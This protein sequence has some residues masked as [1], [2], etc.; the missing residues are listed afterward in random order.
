MGAPD[1]TTPAHH[2]DDGDVSLLDWLRVVADRHVPDTLPA[3]TVPVA[4]LG[5]TSTDD[6]QDPTLS[7]PRQLEA[8]RRALPE[9]FV[10]VAKFYDVESGRTPLDQ[11]GTGTAHERFN[12]PIPRDGGINDLLTEATRP[13][14]RFVAVVSESIERIARTTYL[15]TKIEHDLEQAGVVLLAA[16]EGITRAAIPT[17]NDATAPFRR[18]TPTL[19]RRI[20]QAISEWY[21][22]NMLEL[23]WGGFKEHTIQGF[24]I[25]KPPYGYLAQEVRLDTP[26]ATREGR[27]VKHRLTPDPVRAPVVTQIFTWRALDRLSYRDIATRLNLDPDRYPPP[28]PIPGRG[29]RRIGAWTL[30]SVREVLDNPK[31]TGHMVWNRRKN[32]RKDR[33]VPGRVNPPTAW[34]WSPTPTHE[35]LTTRQMFTAASATG[36]YRKGSRSEPGPN[37]HPA[38]TRT[39]LLRSYLRCD[40]CGRRTYGSTRRTHTYYRCTPN[41]TNHAHQP[42]F[43]DHPANVLIREDH[44]LPPLA[45]FFTDRIFGTHRKTYL[46]ATTATVTDPDLDTRIAALETQITTLQHQQDNL[47]G[48]LANLTPTGNPDVDTAWRRG[49]QT[50]FT[51]TVTTQRTTQQQLATLTQQRGP[52]T[53]V[54][55]DLLDLLPTDQIDPTRLPEDHQRRLYD[56]FHLDLRYNA[57]TREL[58]IRATITRDTAPTIA[59]TINTLTSDHPHTQPPATETTRSVPGGPGCDALRAPGRIR[60]CDTRFR[61]GHHPTSSACYLRFHVNPRDSTTLKRPCGAGVRATNGST[62]PDAV[63]APPTAT[64]DPIR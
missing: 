9:G 51:T 26:G 11:R 2:D 22:L 18:A 57:H 39:Y 49:I 29:R 41:P 23:S 45:E 14:R 60:T 7:L 63:N 27:R 15:S 24:N 46:T 64:E 43:G 6:A 30:N 32:P 4:W 50:R 8:S 47:I 28:D 25:G 37:R 31:H 44:L 36:R 62:P 19:T 54:D 17:P 52:A 16:D 53:P 33:G 10:I 1:P 5:R 40:L 3:A 56:A 58:R 59:T 12:I 42:W 13:D 55:L 20:K 48:E 35:P 34:V 21:V 61:K 38:T